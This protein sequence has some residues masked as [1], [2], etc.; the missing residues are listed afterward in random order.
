M[1]NNENIA[2]LVDEVNCNDL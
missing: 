2:T 1:S